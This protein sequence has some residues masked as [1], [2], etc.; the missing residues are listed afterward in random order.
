MKLAQPLVILR[1][2]KLSISIKQLVQLFT[3][4]IAMLSVAMRKCPAYLQNVCVLCKDISD[5][6][7][8][9]L[10]CQEA[11][12]VV[13]ILPP[14]GQDAAIPAAGWIGWRDMDEPALLPHNARMNPQQLLT[15]PKLMKHV[16]VTKAGMKM[17]PSLT[18]CRSICNR[19]CFTS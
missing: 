17:F 8:Q 13:A 7:P 16:S 6:H 15:I 4:R 1:H 11:N 3:Y 19:M 12:A 14:G 10:C 18:I 5:Q 9:H 2:L